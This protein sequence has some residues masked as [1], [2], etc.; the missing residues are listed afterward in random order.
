[1]K[2]RF[3]KRR[4]AG[5]FSSMN[6]KQVIQLYKKNYKELSRREL[7]QADSTLYDQLRKRSIIQIIPLRKRDFTTMNNSQLITL[8]QKNHAQQSISSFQKK[9]H[10]LYQIALKRRLI[11]ELVL[12]GILQRLIQR[13]KFHSF[14]NK[15]L[16]E[17]IRRNHTGKKISEFSRQDKP[18]YT[19]AKDRGLLDQLEQQGILIRIGHNRRG[20]SYRPKGWCQD[21]VAF[22]KEMK[23]VI[24]HFGHFPVNNDL[25][26]SSYSY[27]RQ[28]ITYHGGFHSVREKMGYARK[29]FP[30]GYWK[31]WDTFS[32]KLLE[33]STLLG[34]FPNKH[35]LEKSGYSNV[36]NAIKFHGNMPKIRERIGYN[37]TKREELAQKLETIVKKII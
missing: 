17:Y 23:T 33:I 36:S 15:E 24:T 32:K 13:K 16:I 21:W 30:Q 4:P 37:Q 6:D 3:F 27:V 2:K 28:G 9:D 7:E 20:T 8:I 25:E 18:A 29:I 22:S 5:F 14:E 31:N 34:Y 12:K 35:D 11:D 26:N 19:V 1:M 10:P